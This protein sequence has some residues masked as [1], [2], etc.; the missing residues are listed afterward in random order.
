MAPLTINFSTAV[1][2]LVVAALVFLAVRRMVRRGLCDSGGSCHG[3]SAGKD[4]G[5][6][7]GCASCAAADRMVADMERAAGQGK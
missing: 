3:C 4:A 7:G 5:S 2:L 1:V 6:R